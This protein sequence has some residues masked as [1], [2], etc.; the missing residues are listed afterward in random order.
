MV[1]HIPYDYSHQ[2]VVKRVISYSHRRSKASKESSKGRVINGE[3]HQ[4]GESP[5]RRVIKE[6]SKEESHQRGRSSKRKVI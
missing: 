4:R 6:K 1:Y 2:K 5:K 3:S